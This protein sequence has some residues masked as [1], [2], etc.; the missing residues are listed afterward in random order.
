L[1]HPLETA[2]LKTH[3][4]HSQNLVN[5]Q[6]IRVHVSSHAKPQARIHPRRIALDWRVNKALQPGKG[7]DLVEPGVNL[8]AAQA[9]DSAVEV[10]VLPP[11]EFGMKAGTQFDERRHPPVDLYLTFGRSGD[12]REQFQRGGLASTVRTDD[13]QRLTWA[14]LKAHVAQSPDVQRISIVIRLAS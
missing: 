1:A 11:G 9:Q 3:I 6:H 14:D 7:H 2:L 4:A 5:Q 12:A 10:D 8:L 13:P